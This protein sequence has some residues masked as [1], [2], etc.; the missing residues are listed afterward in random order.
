[1]PS[2]V[3][4]EAMTGTLLTD[5]RLVPVKIDV[6]NTESRYVAHSSSHSLRLMMS[7]SSL[8]FGICYMMPLYMESHTQTRKSKS[9][10][11]I[12]HERGDISS[13]PRT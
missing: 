6:T 12:G 5:W 10:K 11:M 13:A 7:T 4:K 3:Y 2:R 9:L 1:M 8:H